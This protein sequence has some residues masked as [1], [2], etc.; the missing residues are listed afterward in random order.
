MSIKSKEVFASKN[1][2][3][4]ALSTDL[5]YQLYLLTM[6]LLLSFQCYIVGHLFLMRHV[7]L[8][9]TQKSQPMPKQGVLGN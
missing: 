9:D 8:E 4:Q 1:N 2:Y 6:Q 7:Q 5:D 3:H